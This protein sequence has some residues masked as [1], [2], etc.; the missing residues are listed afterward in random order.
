MGFV[1]VGFSAT[2]YALTSWH[3]HAQL[4]GQVAAAMETLI[5][6]VEVHSDDVTW[7]PYE[8][9]LVLGN[10]SD[11]NQVRWTLH[12]E[13]DLLIDCSTNMSDHFSVMLP[14][15][16]SEWRQNILRMSAGHFIAETPSRVPTPTTAAAIRRLPKQQ[17]MK[18]ASLTLCV[19][20][21]ELPVRQALFKLMIAL[22]CVSLLT[23]TAA[24]LGGRWLCLRALEPIKQ[25]ANKARQLQRTPER[26][27]LL[28]VS[29][30]QD[31]LTDLG[32]AFNQLI[33]TLRESIKRQSR[34]AGDA[35][36]QLRTPL[37]G[38]LMAVDVT[39]RKKRSSEVYEN[40]LAA[41]Q[42]RGRELQEIVET[43]LALTRN[44]SAELS[45]ERIDL[46]DW[47]RTYVEAWAGNERA[48]DLEQR[49]SD[50]PLYVCLP[51]SV[52]VQIVDNLLDNACK[53]GA[54]NTPIV[55]KTRREE[56]YACLVIQDHG[57]GIS[58]K[59]M[60]QLFEPFFRSAEVRSKAL[61][62]FGLGLSLAKHL[63]TAFGGSL[64]ASS[65]EGEGSEFTLKLPLV[66]GV[67]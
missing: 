59:D 67:Q 18:R 35:S 20:L 34:F 46:D 28:V 64:E 44:N 8:R 54:R 11:L 57:P 63:A 41:V 27:G 48:D 50:H 3:L 31:E 62:G 43:L 24:A 32:D 36:H 9:H 42:R 33:L 37:A 15:N 60:T 7:E 58:A 29:G 26:P 16:S 65:V 6:S 23:W 66:A 61:P 19:A 30:N 4:E 17:V 45:N 21:S 56:Q 2:I 5:A 1:L 55:V 13:Q 49:P 22:V 47:C 12:D 39:L 53:Y 25:M 52:L 40:A 14:T 51:K 10:L 38:M